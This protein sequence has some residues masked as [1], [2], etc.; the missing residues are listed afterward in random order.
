[1]EAKTYCGCDISRADIAVI[2]DSSFAAPNG[3]FFADN[4]HFVQ[5]GM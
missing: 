5:G 3:G 1:M 4:A 2:F